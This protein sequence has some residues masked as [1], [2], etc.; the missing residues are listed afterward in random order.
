MYVMYICIYVCISCVYILKDIYIYIYTY[1]YIC[2]PW[3][4]VGLR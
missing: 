2:D 4:L 3:V 1:I